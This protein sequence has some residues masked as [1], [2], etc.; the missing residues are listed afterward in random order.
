MS[1]TPGQSAQNSGAQGV[2]PTSGP[3]GPVTGN[4]ITPSTIPGVPPG[5]PGPYEHK[6]S[7][8][9]YIKPVLW[10]LLLIY[11]VLFVFLNR[12]TIEINF[13]FFTAQVPLIFVLVGVALIGAV[14]SSAVVFWVRRRDTKK[15]KAAAAAAGGPVA[16][17]HKK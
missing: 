15:A 8:T 5:V 16:G 3:Q 2:P 13:I 14:L 6:T 10:T 7:W 4:V 11:I 9:A 12:A 17:K 1:A